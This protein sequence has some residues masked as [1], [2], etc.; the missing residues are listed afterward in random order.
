MLTEL[1]IDARKT[2][3]GLIKF[4]ADET[5]KAGFKKAV[6]GLS[7]GMDSAA[8][9]FLA[10]EAIGKENVFGI[11]MPYQ[12]SSGQDIKDAER[13]AKI[14]G[15]NSRLI[16]IDPMLESFIKILPEMDRIRRGNVMARIRM[17]ILYDQSKP[18]KAL[19]LGTSNKTERLLGYGTI[20]GDMACGLAPLGGLYKTQVRQLAKYLD[21]PGE[22]ISKPPSA[23]LWPGQ[24]DE[25]ELGLRYDEVD[26][27]LYYMIDRQYEDNQL[28]KNGFSH[29][30]ISK[31]RDRIKSSEF[32]RRMPQV[33]EIK[34]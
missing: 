20:Y 14:T 22:I 8:I 9:A 29:G 10:K 2:S 33:A 13:I 4:I 24:T 6:L 19:V 7:G 5:G 16:S 34:Q 18:L 30:M 32:K 21:L 3:A 26:S 1:L 25:G 27:L 15:I 11:I 31:V 12:D 23:G 28:I 17:I